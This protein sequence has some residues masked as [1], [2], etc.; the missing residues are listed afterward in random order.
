[1][2]LGRVTASAGHRTQDL[3]EIAYRS[4]QATLFLSLREANGTHRKLEMGIQDGDTFI[5][6]AHGQFPHR[7]EGSIIGFQ[8]LAYPA[9]ESFASVWQR[10]ASRQA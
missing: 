9:A 8:Q 3:K 6:Q 5:L 4:G 10:L 7:P 2:A 1:M